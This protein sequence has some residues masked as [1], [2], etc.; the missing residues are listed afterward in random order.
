M[1]NEFEL[2]ISVSEMN[3]QNM[4]ENQDRLITITVTND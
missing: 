2:I 4:Q 3:Q 1:Q